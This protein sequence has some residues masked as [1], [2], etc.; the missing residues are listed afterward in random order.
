MNW[1]S[2]CALVLE[3]AISAELAL[4]SAYLLTNAQRRSPA[5][6]L[7][8]A[9]AACLALIFGGN[10]LIGAAGW[11]GLSDVLLA[12]DLLAPP[13]V[14]LYVRQIC[15]PAEPLHRLDILHVLPGLAGL[16]LWK[17]GLLDSMDVYVNACWFGY[18]AFAVHFFWRNRARYAP[19]ALKN[20]V[21]MLLSVLLAI[22]M[23]RIVIVFQAMGGAPFREGLPY[24]LILCVVFLATGRILFTALQHPDLLS[25][26]GSNVKYASST[27]GKA[28]V[29]DLNRRLAALME[30]RRPYL[31]PNV[32]LN[33]LALLLDAP[34]RHI[35]ELINS[36]YGMS[37]PAYMNYCRARIAAQLLAGA[38]NKPVK[39]VMYESG[40]R[41]KSIFNREFQRHFAVSPGRYRDARTLR[42]ETE[43]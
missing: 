23:L 25:V 17:T 8:A 12:L 19:A 39:T 28:Q 15:C 10:L 6:Y 24:L 35:S 32:T 37:F 4:F 26:P 22:G 41:S 42:R 16:L 34:P 38:P 9:L 29:D 13:T 18:L 5:L 3:S 31:D 2:L 43:P 11:L 20:F 7:L 21:I 27:L 36:R 33:R 40:F 30:E 1:R 14:Y